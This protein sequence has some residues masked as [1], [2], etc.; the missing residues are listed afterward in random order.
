MRP[1][2]IL[3]E[4]L[5]VQDAL[6]RHR[7]LVVEARRQPR[8]EGLIW[9]AT[10]ACNLACGHCGNP[11]EGKEGDGSWQHGRELKTDEVK[12]IFREVSEDFPPGT[13][14]IGITGGEATLRPDLCEI[15]AYMRELGF[16]V[17]LTTNGFLTGKDPELLDRLVDAGVVLFTIS[18][19]GLREGHDRQ[20]GIPG[21]FDLVVKTLERLRDEHPEVEVVVNTC[22]TPYNWH[23]LP[24]LYGLMQ[25]LKIKKWHVG[26]VSPVGRAVAPLTHLTNEQIRDL[27]E[28]MAEKNKPANVEASGIQLTWF[29]DGWVGSSF[30]GRVREQGMFFCGAGT[31][32]A[33]VLYDGKAATCL[34]VRRDIGVQGDLRRERLKDVWE[35]R[36]EWFR[37]DREKFRKGPCETC[38]EWDWCQG[39]SLHLREKDGT[40]V[41]CIFHRQSQAKPRENGLPSVIETVE[42]AP[43]TIVEREGVW[44]VGNDDTGTF[45]EMPAIGVAIVRAL[46]EEPHVEKARERVRAQHQRDVDVA[47][48][49]R[50][51]AAGGFVAKVN[52]APLEDAALPPR[53]RKLFEGV[54]PESL[55]WMRS[56]A[57]FWACVLPF[58]AALGAMLADPWYVP[59]WEDFLVSEIY[60]LVGLSVFLF[61]TLLVL[62]HELG[63]VL[64]ARALGSRASLGLSTRLAYLVVQTDASNLWVL[65]KKD[66]MKVY[67]AG[68]ATDL[69]VVGVGTLLLALGREGAV[70]ALAQPTFVAFTKL[71]VV[72]SVA[73]ILFQFFFQVRTDIYYIVAHGIDCRN[74]YGDAR[75]WLRHH[76][77]RV[78][79][80]WRTVPQPDVSARERPWVRAY[81]LLHFVGVGVFFGYFFGFVVPMLLHVYGNA[82]GHLWD[83]LRY[84]GAVP[85]VT[86]IDST[87]FFFVHI[88]YFGLVGWLAWRER[89]RDA[90]GLALRATDDAA[91]RRLLS[92]PAPQGML[93]TVG[94]K[95]AQLDPQRARQVAVQLGPHLKAATVRERRK[96]GS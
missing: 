39:S 72:A 48:F 32:I 34:E 44:V 12:R 64:M 78:V 55:R 47:A 86:V 1:R 88:A 59:G 68:M 74:L 90:T 83:A 11:V 17:S 76:F 27:L 36:Y 54:K 52:G 85:L 82:I 38:A 56:P 46:Q 93:T 42:L 15:V 58:G 35:R 60:T 94:G 40:L 62:K 28:W 14:S 80:R 13:L 53:R 81:A 87:A 5:T 65:S 10:L 70:P 71:A 67:A 30:E 49:V 24:G 92:H 16:R 57:F 26:P 4:L 45:A 84:P 31:R 7:D 50:S 25:E 2:P 20:R 77:G 69:F 75:Q 66:R 91:T 79:P 6:A 19:D 18:V 29:C 22:V 43:L 23:D 63:H 96:Q 51:I 61:F 89:K 37:E 33:S 95:L 9:E 3:P 21:S 41:E 8:L 73:M